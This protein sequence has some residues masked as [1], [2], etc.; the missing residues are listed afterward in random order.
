M[1]DISKYT[2]KIPVEA[3]RPLFQEAVASALH[4]APRGSYILIW[5]ACAEGLK[6]RFVYP[7]Q[8]QGLWFH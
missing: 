6:R 4:G 1:A 2:A 5:I 7:I 3:D 8:R